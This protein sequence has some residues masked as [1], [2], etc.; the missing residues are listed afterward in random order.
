[1]ELKY[2]YRKKRVF[3]F[4]R[5]LR[6]SARGLNV[7]IGLEPSTIEYLRTRFQ[8]LNDLEPIVSLS[9]DEIF[10][11]KKCEYASGQFFGF[12]GDA[13]KT[14]LAFMINGI[15]SSHRD[16]VCLVPL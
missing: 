15:A 5:H 10:T 11:N 7:E 8:S 9:F 6:T 16:V 13:T 2:I 1:M 3:F 12:D 14:I 4:F